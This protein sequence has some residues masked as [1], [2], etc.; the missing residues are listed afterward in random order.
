M[1]Q[2]RNC[3]SFMSDL[4]IQRL[5]CSLFVSVIWKRYIANSWKPAT[6]LCDLYSAFKKMYI[7]ALTV[8]AI[9]TVSYQR[10]VSHRRM[11][12]I[13]MVFEINSLNGK[14]NNL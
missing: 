6:N 12:A 13:C 14:P 2:Q 1:Q 3:P 11:K 5:L 9:C 8:A 4:F 7:R 10:R